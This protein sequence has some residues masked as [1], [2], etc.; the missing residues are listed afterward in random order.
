VS[1]HALTFGAPVLTAIALLLFIGAMGKSAQIPFT[2]GCL[3]PWKA[4]RR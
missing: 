2:F 1:A 3:T 4:Q